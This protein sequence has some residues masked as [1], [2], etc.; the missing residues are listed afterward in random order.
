[1]QLYAMETAPVS[2][3]SHFQ[4]RCVA[5]YEKDPLFKDE[6]NLKQYTCRH[7]LWWAPEGFAENLR[8]GAQRAKECLQQAQQ[9]QKAY[10]DKG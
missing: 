6:S 10:A 9:R 7:G 4:K 1:M 3:L 2:A 5:A 8:L